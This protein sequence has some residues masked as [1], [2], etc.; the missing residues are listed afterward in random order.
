MIKTDQNMN[1]PQ[2]TYEG[3]C[4]GIN[5]HRCTHVIKPGKEFKQNQTKTLFFEGRALPNA[6]VA[7]DSTRRRVDSPRLRSAGGA[8]IG[9]SPRATGG[10]GFQ[11]VNREPCLP[12]APWK[13]RRT[14]VRPGG[15]I[16]I[17]GVEREG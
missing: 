2:K 16:F 12:C 1:Q 4:I 6:R 5:Y 15:N 9:G 11:G 7:I 17:G 8:N 14:W 13:N 3:R 10:G